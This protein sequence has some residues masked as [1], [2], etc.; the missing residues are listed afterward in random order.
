MTLIWAHTADTLPRDP[1]G[2]TGDRIDADQPKRRIAT[3][4][5]ALMQRKF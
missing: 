2:T 3:G 4:G 1:Q 5:T